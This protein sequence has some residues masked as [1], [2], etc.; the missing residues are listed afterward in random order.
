LLW[1]GGPVKKRSV[2]NVTEIISHDVPGRSVV[3]EAEAVTAWGSVFPP[4]SSAWCISCV[5]N[6]ES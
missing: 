5:V 3:F 1:R 6:G 4:A 2:E